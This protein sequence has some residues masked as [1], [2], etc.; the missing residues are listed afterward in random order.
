MHSTERSILG[1]NTVSKLSTPAL[2]VVDTGGKGHI[3][4]NTQTEPS[5]LFN[6]SLP[7]HTLDPITSFSG[8]NRVS[9]TVTPRLPQWCPNVAWADA[10]DPHTMLGF[11]DGQS[12]TKCS[13]CSLGCRVRDGLCLTKRTNETAHVDDVALGLSQMRQSLLADGEVADEIELKQVLHVG[14]REVIDSARRRMPSSIIDDAVQS[15]KFLDSLSDYIDALIDVGD[16]GLH[17]H[18]PTGV[19][20]VGVELGLQL[21]ALVNLLVTKHDAAGT[22]RQKDTDTTLAYTHGSTRN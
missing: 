11:V 7:L 21:L 13:R 2:D 19:A 6:G 9:L 10:I 3:S 4:C 16:I 1:S 22:S 12:F 17:K 8:S 18:R 20:V 14:H 5:G 15:A